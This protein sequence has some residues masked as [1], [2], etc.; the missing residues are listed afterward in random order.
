[1]SNEQF[2]DRNMDAFSNNPKKNLEIEN[3]ILRMKISAEMGGVFHITD[4]LPPH[5]E[6]EFLKNMIDFEQQY[7]KSKKVKVAALIGNPSLKKEADLDDEMIIE[8][9]A[10]IEKLL[11]AKGIVAGF[12][13]ERDARFRYKFITEEFLEHETDDV[14]IHGMTKHYLYE[15]FHQDHEADIRQVVVDF[16][17]D[18]FERKINSSSW[19]FSEQFVHPNGKLISKRKMIEKI[20]RVFESYLAFKDCHYS[21]D[22]IKFELRDEKPGEFDGFGFVEGCISYTAVLE[23]GEHKEINGPF[24]FY[25]SKHFDSWFI[26]FFYLTGFN[27]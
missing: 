23:N 21:L 12:I 4:K 6:N 26:F 18:W 3:E 16:L 27:T 7:A 19:Y 20:M 10:L 15:E 8:E 22:E 1:M 2:P 9:L 11:S 17:E 5:I 25:L 13:K 24:K 14:F